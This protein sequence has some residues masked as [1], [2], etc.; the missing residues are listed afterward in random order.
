MESRPTDPRCRA[1]EGST[2]ESGVEIFRAKL[3]A[4]DLCFWGSKRL[5]MIIIILDSGGGRVHRHAFE[6]FRIFAGAA[7][8]D[9][10][11]HRPRLFLSLRFYFPYY[12]NSI[13]ILHPLTPFLISRVSVLSAETEA[14]LRM[15][16]FISP[17]YVQKIDLLA[18]EHAEKTWEV[19]SGVLYLLGI[20]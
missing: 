17:G 2:R 14:A 9:H 5:I 10:Q 4:S 6:E 16:C 8:Q 20:D 7:E 12:D 3:T 15:T 19:R 18:I 11:T 1:P 13:Q